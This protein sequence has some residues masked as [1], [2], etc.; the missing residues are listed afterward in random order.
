[1][2]ASKSFPFME[3]V[4]FHWTM[5][6]GERVKTWVLR[7][8]S[9]SKED[10]EF[11]EMISEWSWPQMGDLQRNDLKIFAASLQE[12]I[13]AAEWRSS[14]LRKPNGCRSCGKNLRNVTTMVHGLTR[15]SKLNESDLCHCKSSFLFKHYRSE[16]VHQQKPLHLGPLNSLG[17]FEAQ[18]LRRFT[19][20]LE[21]SAHWLEGL[22]VMAHDAQ[23]PLGHSVKGSNT[24]RA[25]FFQRWRKRVK[26]YQYV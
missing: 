19:H 1:M 17:F 3:G 25:I 9:D 4:V 8:P 12:R 20:A 10:L 2:V 23:L 14:A 16:S 21:G 22:A 11:D 7:G 18:Q 5:I 26:L 24:V 13:A 15:W 6:V